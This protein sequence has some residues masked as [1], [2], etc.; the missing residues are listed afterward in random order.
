MLRKKRTE[1]LLKQDPTLKTTKK[2]RKALRKELPA[3]PNVLL[4]QGICLAVLLYVCHEC[5]RLKSTGIMVTSQ[6]RIA[7]ALNKSQQ[8]VSKAI[9][10]LTDSHLLM[11]EPVDARHA[12]AGTI[13]SIR[14][15]RNYLRKALSDRRTFYISIPNVVIKDLKKYVGNP[16]DLIVGLTKETYTRGSE[17]DLS[18]KLMMLCSGISKHKTLVK[19]IRTVRGIFHITPCDKRRTSYTVTQLHPE[20]HES[21]QAAKDAAEEK[22]QDS[23]ANNKL[24]KPN[25]QARASELKRLM[26]ELLNTHTQINGEE[27]MKCPRCKGVLT[28]NT[29]KGHFGIVHCHNKCSLNDVCRKGDQL[30]AEIKHVS[31]ENARLMLDGKPVKLAVLAG[32][33]VAI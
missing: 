20:T 31:V 32:E 14:K 33:G 19:A 22:A 17:F 5:N 23:K 15:Q 29:S 12:S 16:L 6:P 1:E 25:T 10:S 30:V 2:I 27:A 24:F 26:Q 7:A 13:L 8:A 28:I 18:T 3:D 11:A 9:N 21:L 4:V